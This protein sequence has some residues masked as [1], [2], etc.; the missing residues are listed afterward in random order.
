MLA[1]PANGL[2]VVGIYPQ[3][4]LMFWDV[5]PRGALSTRQLVAGLEAAPSRSVINLSLGSPFR[6]LLIEH[7]VLNAFDRGVIIV[8]A[9]GNSGLGRN[10]VSFPAALS[11]VLTVGSTG[12]G[13][14]V[15]G[16]ST[17]SQTVDV[18]APGEQIPVAVPLD[19]DPS[20][21]RLETG[22][23]FSAPIVAGAV[24]WLWTARPEL[25][26]TQVT[27]LIRQTA[28]DIGAP[29]RDEGSGFGVLDVPGALTEPPPPI[30]P[31]E[32]NDDVDHLVAGNLFARAKP[33]LTRP[34]KGRAT[35]RAR[36]DT[37]EDPRDVYRVWA[38]PGR[39]ITATVRSAQDVDLE[40]WSGEVK[41]VTPSRSDRRLHLL[42]TITTVQPRR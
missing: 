42:S 38:P 3:V 23:S 35:V 9:S 2:G 25:D 10:A 8:A 28:R 21:Y 29:G 6:D 22:T 26:K 34:G 4:A 19:V 20:G 15:S 1:A 36:L 14:A 41:T 18:A 32:P 5:S 13:D 40:I 30:D 31:L 24:A 37:S 11:H 39:R 7:A 33:P 27:E 12:P 17:R 16:F